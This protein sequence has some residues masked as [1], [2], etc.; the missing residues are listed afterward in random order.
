MNQAA[1]G[2]SF[3]KVV[4]SSHAAALVGAAQIPLEQQQLHLGMRVEAR[5]N[6]N[7]AIVVVVMLPQTQ[8]E[9]QQQR[10]RRWRLGTAVGHTI[11]PLCLSQNPIDVVKQQLLVKDARLQGRLLLLQLLL[12]LLLVELIMR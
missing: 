8:K 11:R 10:R 3:W 9:K 12:Q 1:L 2:A 5:H 6:S 7:N 4:S